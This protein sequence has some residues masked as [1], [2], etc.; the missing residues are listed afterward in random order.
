MVMTVE[1]I[2]FVETVNLLKK[3]V[4]HLHHKEI[5]PPQKSDS[6]ASL[7]LKT[8]SKLSKNPIAVGDILSQH[9]KT[10]Q[11]DSLQPLK[12]NPPS[13]KQTR[14]AN[15]E[16]DIQILSQQIEQLKTLIHTLQS[17]Q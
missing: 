6:T 2:N 8:S 14:I 13:Q 15:V 12:T 9:I 3:F 17:K 16:R 10:L 7:T 5:Q 1:N 4:D 11:T